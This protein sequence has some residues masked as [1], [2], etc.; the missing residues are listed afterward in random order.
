VE[1]ADQKVFTLRVDPD[2]QPIA[3]HLIEADGNAHE[4]AGWIGLATTL[5]ELLGLNPADPDRPEAS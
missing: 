2:A 3:G 4:F 5:E 1:T